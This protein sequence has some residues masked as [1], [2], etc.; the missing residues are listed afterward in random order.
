MSMRTS[1]IQTQKQILAPVMQQSIAVLML[2]LTELTFAIEQELQTNPLLE[3]EIPQ[4]LHKITNPSKSFSSLNHFNDIPTAANF[5]SSEEEQPEIPISQ[6]ESLNDHLLTQLHIEISDPLKQKIGELIIGNL[7]ADGYLT[8][9]TDELAL[10]AGTGD[11]ALVEEVLHT[12]QCFDPLGIASRNI[13]E[14]LIIQ[15]S[16]NASSCRSNAALI[17]KDHFNDLCHKRLESIAHKT[18]MSLQDVKDAAHL[19]ATLEPKP[20]RN[21][22]TGEETIYVHPDIFVSRNA[23]GTFRVE[24]NKKEVPVMRI[25]PIYQK[26]LDSK[27]LNE[28]ERK[29]IQ[30]KMTN[31]INFIKSVAQRGETLLNISRYIVDH[32]KK[33][34]EGDTSSL[35]PMALKEIAEVL[36]RNE[37]TISRAIHSKYMQ[38]PQGIFPLKFFFSGAVNEANKDISS[39]NVK[40]EIKKLIETENKKHPLSDQDILNHFESKGLKM[41]RRTIN[42]YRQELQIPSSHMRKK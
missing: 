6:S 16:A 12:I 30:D 26:L 40:E 28:E 35:T 21:Y 19:I 1:P 10:I 41:A 39:H 29:F 2:S 5:Q 17:I 31:A 9:P 24:V 36:E 25:N 4:E 34:F 38:T 3:A 20:A 15:L 18:E 8:T 13:E 7:D 42:K 27:T 37:S 22:Q 32:Q 14:C 11:I 33:F 23:E